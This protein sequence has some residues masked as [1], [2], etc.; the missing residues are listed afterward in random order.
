[1]TKD[2]KTPYDK[3][4][5]RTVGSEGPLSEDEEAGVV[6]GGGDETACFPGGSATQPCSTGASAIR[7]CQNGGGVQIS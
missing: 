5:A 4:E 2:D 7:Q 1:M 3:P 6:G